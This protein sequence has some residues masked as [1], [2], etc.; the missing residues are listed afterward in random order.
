MAIALFLA[1]SGALM[2]ALSMRRHRR[3]LRWN[4]LTPHRERLQRSGGLV[5]AAAALVP[6]SALLGMTIGIV[7]WL[8]IL[9]VGILTAIAFVT[10]LTKRRNAR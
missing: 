4:A 9:S 2:M 1:A 7:A 3:D 6:T 10:W 5:L 8:M